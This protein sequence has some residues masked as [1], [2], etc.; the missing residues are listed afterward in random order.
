[1]SSSRRH[2]G[3]INILAMLD[4]QA[5]GRR[6]RAVPAV[7]W[8]GAAG[9]LACS[10]LVV[11]AWLVRGATPARDAEA[12]GTAQVAPRPETARPGTAAATRDAAGDAIHVN[13]PTM[14]TTL[15][16]ETPAPAS[17]PAPPQTAEPPD[18]PVPATARGAVIVDVAPSA[19]PP[20][21]AAAA[22]PAAAARAAGAPSSSAPAAAGYTPTRNAAAAVPPARPQPAYRAVPPQTPLL[23]HGEPAPSR[24][25]RAAA[26]SRARPPAATVDTDVA[27][28]SAILQHA[29]AGNDGADAAG[30]PACTGKSCNPRLPS[31]Q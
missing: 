18:T 27:L 24:Q 16:G 15:A 7:F 28:I 25:K 13:V 6:L 17:M 19:A 1:M 12:A 26:A 30:T 8:Y 14:H 22:T 3:E 10:L 20:S 5:P 2:G 29:G 23:A 9:I 4:G 21:A 11:L 31:R